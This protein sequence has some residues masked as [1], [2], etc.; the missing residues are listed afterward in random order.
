MVLDVATLTYSV[1]EGAFPSVVERGAPTAYRNL[2]IHVPVSIAAYA[3]LTLAAV[4]AL[5]YMVSRRPGFYALAD[6]SVKI[7]LPLGLASFL[8]G[9]VWASESWGSFWSWDP[10]QVSILI[11]V[12]A[13]TLYFAVKNSVRDPDRRPLVASA[14]M[15]AAYATVPLSFVLPRIAESLHPTPE[16][17]RV[18]VAGAPELFIARMA[19]VVALP[20]AF[21]AAR[22][23]VKVKPPRALVALTLISLAAILAL[24]A[25]D[26][27]RAIGG[28]AGRVLDAKLEGG[29]L[30]V[31]VDANGVTREGYYRGPPPIEPLTVSIGGE[32]RV[33][34]V[35]NIVAFKYTGGVFEELSVVNHPVVAVNTAI[36]AILL[37][38][39]LA[40][41]LYRWGEQG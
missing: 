31:K 23:F 28:E 36:Y 29:Q 8:T 39:V 21:I 22:R 10:R 5:A 19:I 9:S 38:T 24:S 27:Y 18:F 40:L 34:L 20:L 7:G 3:T 2:Y 26:L 32:E 4:L 6:F 14:Y 33:T 15:F 25:F 11:L 37:Y 30:W 41:T 12:L 17:T 13:Y 16:Q 35:G 1:L